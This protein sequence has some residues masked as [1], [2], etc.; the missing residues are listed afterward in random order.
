MTQVCCPA[1]RLRFSPAASAYIVACPQ[2]GEPPQAALSRESTMGF[3][4]VGADEFEIEMPQA[5]A[6]AIP[7]PEPE[8]S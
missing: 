8:G 6:V 1:C 3:R 4:L 7:V 2:C 5:V